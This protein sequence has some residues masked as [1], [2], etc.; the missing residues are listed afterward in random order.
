MGLKVFGDIMEAK[1]YNHLLF[2]NWLINLDLAIIATQL[3]LNLDK[4]NLYYE[5]IINAIL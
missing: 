1:I 5:L 4:N 3:Y 2:K